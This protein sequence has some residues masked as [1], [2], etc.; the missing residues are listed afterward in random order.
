MHHDLTRR[1]LNVEAVAN[2]SL[3]QLNSHT[4]NVRRM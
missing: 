4:T 2:L 3:L 1:V